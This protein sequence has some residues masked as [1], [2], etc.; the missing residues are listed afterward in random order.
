MQDVTQ[1]VTQAL[2]QDVD[3]R[4]R[5]QMTRGWIQNMLDDDVEIDGKRTREADFKLVSLT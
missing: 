1:D 2:T 4:R 5:F 3:A